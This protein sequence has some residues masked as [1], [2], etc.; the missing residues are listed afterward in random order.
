[1]IGS[2]RKT[3]HANVHKPIKINQLKAFLNH[4]KHGENPNIHSAN[5][6]ALALGNVFVAI[7]PISDIHFCNSHDDVY[8]S[9]QT[10][11]I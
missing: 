4:R 7:R 1:M 9:L 3:M 8:T 2:L 10:A 5:Y 6:L 11:N